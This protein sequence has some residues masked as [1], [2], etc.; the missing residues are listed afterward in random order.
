MP[1]CRGS[2]R[3]GALRVQLRSVFLPRLCWLFPPPFQTQAAAVK[4]RQSKLRIGEDRHTRNPADET[5]R[6]IERLIRS[7]REEMKPQVRP[8][9]LNP[10]PAAMPR[11]SKR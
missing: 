11:Q 6:E 7:M 8:L 1:N 9:A 2:Q 5:A 10:P 3:L 4:K